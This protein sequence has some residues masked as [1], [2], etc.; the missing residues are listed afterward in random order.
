M[1]L[2]TLGFYQNWIQSIDKD[3]FKGLVNLEYLTI[4]GNNFTSVDPATFTHTPKMISLVMKNGKLLKIHA[5]TFA[6]LSFLDS[7]Y[8]SENEIE[9]LP[10]LKFGGIQSLQSIN[11]E[12][13][14]I[15]EIDP[16][17]LVSYPGS[18]EHFYYLMTDNICVSGS[19][20][21]V[22]QLIDWQACVN[23]WNNNHPT[24]STTI[25]SSS[26]T[27]A[28][29]S[30]TF[31]PSPSPPPPSSPKPPCASCISHKT[32]RYFL[33]HDDVY[34]CVIEDVQLAMDSIT[35]EHETINGKT[36]TDE[37]VKAVYLKNSILSIVPSEIFK[38]FP[39]IEF[40]SIPNTQMTIID[41]NTFPLCGI[42]LKRLDVSGNQITKITDSSLMKCQALELINLSQNPF[43]DLNTELFRLD[44]QL[45]HVI[46]N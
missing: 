3:A 12:K 43:E 15:N 30:T 34:S 9:S 32:C 18:R 36:F 14:K 26:T 29:S 40:L 19:Y 33:D 41:D 4:N 27:I 7:L 39:N 46:L 23:N 42:M 24:S 6:T 17:I 44:P 28:H 21:M 8:L 10:A 38:N 31:A 13:N 22:S 37:N 35:G 11:F 20:S 1:N 16:E 45:K 2:R 25:V 5:D